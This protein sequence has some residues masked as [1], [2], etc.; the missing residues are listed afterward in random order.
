MR[1]AIVGKYNYNIFDRNHVVVGLYEV[2][3]PTYSFNGQ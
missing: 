2:V 3:R 1:N